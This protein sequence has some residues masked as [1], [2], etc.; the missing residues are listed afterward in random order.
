MNRLKHLGE[1][2]T[3]A[4]IR[5]SYWV[6]DVTQGR[7]FGLILG[8]SLIYFSSNF[9]FSFIISQMDNKSSN[10]LWLLNL[11]CFGINDYL[12]LY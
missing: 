9:S 4:E 8:I 12:A 6:P 11:T 5:C 3:L 10:F 7:I 1:Q 2:Q